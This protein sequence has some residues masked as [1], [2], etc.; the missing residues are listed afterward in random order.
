MKRIGLAWQIFIGLLLGIAV[1][2]A[3]YGNPE[4]A[5]Y[6]QPVGD[7]F[8]RLIKMIV[9]PIVISSLIVGVANVGDIKKLGKLGGKTI[10]YFEIITT[11]AIVVGLLAANVFHPGTGVNMKTLEKTDI[12]AYVDTTHEV[13]SHSM[14]DT[15]V[16]IVPKNIFEALST[17]NML[18]IIFFSVMFGLGVAAIGEKGK[19]VLQFFQ[20]TAD[21]MFYMTNQIMKFAP[22]GVFALIGVTVSK[23]GVQSLIPLSKLVIVVYATMIFFVVVVLGIVA[24]LVK[25]NLWHMIKILKDELVLAYS[26]ASSET[27][28]P[29]IMEKMEKFG[30]PK[31]ITSFVIPTGYSFNLDG[32][33][34][35]QALAAIFIAQLYGIDMPISQ[36]LSLLLVLMVTSKGIAGVPGVS[37]VVLLATLGTVGIPV[38]GLAFI[39]GIDRILDMAR[40][41]VNV[42]GNSLAAVVMSKWEGQYNEEKAAQYVNEVVKSA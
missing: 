37:F 3:F 23:F 32:S 16:N 10:L 7:I 25:V 33:T 13:Q 26:T 17:G 8:L 24:K 19:V 20:G 2:A 28:L 40:T 4:V 38:E 31:A 29:K 41:A 39:A 27:V 18:A 5:T 9:I 36:Q 34:L 11:I 15:V 42:I 35:Y 22:F 12:Q 6:L 1:G 21:A 14:I 30:C